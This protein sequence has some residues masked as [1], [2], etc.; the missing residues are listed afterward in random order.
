MP[1]DSNPTI[2]INGEQIEIMPNSF[3]YVK[4]SEPIEQVTRNTVAIS[5]NIGDNSFKI[6]MSVD[7]IKR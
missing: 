7:D 6:E 2:E 3:S 4:R 1:N 5:G